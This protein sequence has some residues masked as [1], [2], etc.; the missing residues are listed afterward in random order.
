MVLRRSKDPQL[1]ASKRLSL[2]EI[3]SRLAKF[4]VDYRDVKNE[5]QHTGDFWKA[6]MR[7]YGIEDSFLHGVTFEYP[8]KRSDTGG[9]GFID[10]FMPGKYLIEQKT[11]GKIVKAKGTELSNAEQQAH[12]YLTGGTITEAQMPRWVVTSDFGTVQITDMSV[13]RQSPVRTKTIRTAD[14]ADYAETFLFLTGEDVESLIIEDQ[15]EASVTAARLM[16]DLY[17]AITGDDDTDGTEVE[18]AEDEDELTMR[19]SVLLTRLLF[20]MFGDDAGLWRRGLFGRFIQSRTAKDGTDLGQ[21]LAA[22]FLVLDTPEPRPKRMDEELREFPYVNGDLF[23][24]GETDMMWFDTAMRDA[25]LAACAFDWSRI[26]PAVFGSLFQTVKSKAARRGDGEHYTSEANILK[27]IRPLFLD[28]LRR[29]LDAANTKPALEALHAE[30]ATYRYVDPACGCGNFLIVAYREMRALELDLL[31]KLKTKRGTEDHLML[32]PGGLLSVRL[33]QFYGIELNWWPAKI[34]ETAMYLVDHQA[35]RQMEKALGIVPNRLPIEIAANIH[36]DNALTADWDDLL[37]GPEH[38]VLMFGNP[39][40]LGD[41]TRDSEQLGQLQTAWGG[42]KQLSRLDFVTGWHAKAMRY[43]A[44]RKGEFAFV[45]TNSIVQGDQVHR[46]FDPLY[47]AGWLIKF[48]H[49]TFAW[50]SETAAKDRAAVH[51]VIVGFTRDQGCKP[52]L[53]EYPAIKGDAVEVPVKRINGYLVDGPDISVPKR[54][55]PLSPAL[56]AVHYG[57]KPTDDG[58]LVVTADQYPEVAKDPVAAKYLRRYVGSKELINNRDRWCLWMKDLVPGDID[59]SPVLTARVSAVQA[60]RSI[61]KAASTRDYP[62]HHL[63]RQIGQPTVAYLAIPEVFSNNRPYATAARLDADVI[64]SNKIYVC[65]DPDGFAFAIISSS[66]YL[67]WQKTVGGRLKS[68]PSFSSTI[69]WNNLPLPGVEPALRTKIA[70]A[71]KAVLDARAKD[72]RSLAEQYRPLGMSPDLVD[73]HR[74]LDRVVDRAFGAP[75]GTNTEAARQKVLFQRYL[76]LTEE[77]SGR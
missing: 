73:A 26:S 70:D 56:D 47:E 39:P 68:D 69:V 61:S 27:T 12:A 28:D 38:R 67:A 1:P 57:S 63:F 52:R 44:K 11:D 21:Q 9:L 8:A 72:A 54:S 42:N 76:E 60:F 53:F 43:L 13:T 15:I 50:N 40:F 23:K 41:H 2:N 62:H 48:A 55:K 4:A 59:R 24:R 20:L 14:I 37:P 35:N 10:V 25:L 45:T 66:M 17:A 49:R 18:N 58:Q 6:F 33:D 75:R 19:A 7:C 31:V 65:P 36:H 77:G 30:L 46:L 71:G 16:G 5:K 32:D 22:L 64:A 29:R 74:A 51:C 3:R 34:A